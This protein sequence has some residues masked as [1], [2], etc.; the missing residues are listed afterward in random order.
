MT[1]TGKLLEFEGVGKSFG[2]LRA[3][4]DVSFTVSE[5]EIVGL[6]GPNGAG[7]TT[8]FAMA[9]GF[10]KPTDGR[11]HFQGRRIDGFDPPRICRAGLVRTFQIVKPFGEMTVIE[12]AMVGA[13]LHHPRP[14]EARELAAA[15]LKQVGLG[16]REEQVAKTLTL[17]GRKRLEVAK[18]LATN[19]K[20]LLLDEVMA[21][22]NT[23]ET[24]E[25]VE[26]IHSLR[27]S[28][29][30]ILVIE[31]NMKAV[32]NLSDK[33]VVIQYGKKIA[34]GLPAEVANDPQVISAYLGGEHVA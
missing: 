28:G 21:G 1:M 4:D 30:S 17:S 15:V 20:L 18:A 2:G 12:N 22:L 6:I 31:H 11:I 8:L 16:G 32:M 23:V 5:N 9:S 19:P 7:K 33:I 34:E 25:M 26:L 13:F 29:V 10:L 27:A 24:A 14:E 3:I